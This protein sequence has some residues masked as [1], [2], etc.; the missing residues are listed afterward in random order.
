[1]YKNRRRSRASSGKRVWS[2]S[3]KRKKRGARKEGK[4]YMQNQVMAQVVGQQKV[5]DGAAETSL[6]YE[7]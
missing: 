5:N 4:R 3:S 2:W 7:G 1:M 6:N